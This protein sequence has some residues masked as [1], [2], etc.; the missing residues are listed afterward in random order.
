MR[1]ILSDER[2]NCYGL[3]FLTAGIDI[4]DFVKNPVMLYMHGRG[5]VIGRWE[6]IK[7]EGAQLTA[8]AVFNMKDEFAASKAQQ[9]EDGFLQ[10]C[11][12]G[13]QPLTWSE[14]PKLLVTGQTR[15]TATQSTLLEA[16][17]VDIPGNRNALKLFLGNGLCLSEDTT[18]NA[19]TLDKLLPTLTPKNARRMNQIL[20]ALRLGENATEAEAVAAIGRIQKDADKKT[21]DTIIAL[22]E[23]A[24]LVTA[25]NKDRFVQLAAAAPNLALSFLDF[26]SLKPAAGGENKTPAE[27]KTLKDAINLAAQQ[28]N[29]NPA[30]KTGILKLADQRKEWTIRD[31]E[32]KDSAGLV[33]LRAQDADKYQALYTDYYGTK[34]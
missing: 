10:A 6:D 4:K 32:K 30:E 1:F 7:K 13:L 31:W 3:R 5:Q 20:L 27:R 14:D 25:D 9:V 11:S 12:S 8:E 26:G 19:E 18:A 16:S 29:D 24:G 2:V 22:A 28:N 34:L 23:Q 21:A 33:K 17:I 15:P